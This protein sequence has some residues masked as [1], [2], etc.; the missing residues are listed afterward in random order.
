MDYDE[1]IEVHPMA[2]VLETRDGFTRLSSGGDSEDSAWFCDD[3]GTEAHPD[4][5][6]WVC[7][8]EE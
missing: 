1:F 6:C 4:E 3:C 2:D 7:H 5:C 8:D